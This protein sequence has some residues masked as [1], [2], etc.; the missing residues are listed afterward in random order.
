MGTTNGHDFA[1]EK[2]RLSGLDVVF[3]SPLNHPAEA[4]C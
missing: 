2:A 1:R 3:V 4:G